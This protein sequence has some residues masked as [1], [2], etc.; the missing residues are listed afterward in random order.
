MLAASATT[1]LATAAYAQP[2]STDL[3]TLTVPSSTPITAAVSAAGVVWYK[4]TLTESISVCALKYMDIYS[5][6]GT[7]SSNDSEIGL[8]S[9]T[10]ALIFSDDDDGPG[11]YSALSFGAGSD[12]LVG[13]TGVLSNGRDRNL[14]PGEYYLAVSAFS[15]THNTTGWSVTSTSTATGNVD[16][17]LNLGTYSPP[18][19]PTATD[20]G[21]LA[22]NDT[23]TDT[24]AIGAGATQWYKVTV[25]DISHA[26]S[27]FVDIDT[28]GT[29]LSTNSTRLT[30]Y[31]LAGRL[32][33]TDTID[34]SGS[35]SQLS[36][37][38]T[39]PTRPA[40]GTSV[41]YNGRDGALA[42]CTYY[43]AVAPATGSVHG[44]NAFAATSTSTVT[45]NLKVN[46]NAGAPVTNPT[47]VPSSVPVVLGVS[48]GLVRVAV[49]PGGNPAST[50]I[51]VTADLTAV[52]GSSTQTLFDNGTNGD[53]TSG[54]N[55]YSF[56]VS[57]AT[58]AGVFALPYTVADLELRSSGGN[59]SLP[60]QGVTD[61]G[62]LT[63]PQTLTSAD[64]TIPA[65]TITWFKFTIPSVS[66]GDADW[67]DIVTNATLAG[68]TFTADTHMGLFNSA[69]ALATGS[70]ATS[71]DDDDGPAA[72]SALTYGL[73]SP[74]RANGDGPVHNGRD[75]SLAAGTYYLAVGG[76]S[77]AF[78]AG[79][80]ATSTSNHTSGTVGVTL[81]LGNSA[82]PTI[83]GNSS[84]TLAGG[85]A[86]VTGTVLAGTS[87]ASTSYTVTGNFSS[88]G[89]S[90]TQTMYDDMTN[91]DLIPGDLVYSYAFAVSGAQPAGSYGVPLSVVDNLARAG[92]GNATVAVD[93][94]GDA[95]ANARL[96]DGVGPVTSVSGSLGA[97][98][99][100]MMRL[101][102]C[103]PASFSA[104]TVG[105]TTMDTQLFLFNADGSGIV[106][107][108]DNVVPG[109]GLQSA[110]TSSFTSSLPAGDYYLAIT[111]YDKDPVDAGALE[112]W[113]DQ[114]GSPLTYRIEHA[115]DGLGANALAGWNLAGG[116]GGPY[117]ISLSGVSGEP[118]G[119]VCGSADFDGDGDVGTD[120]DIEAFFACLGGDCCAT[121]G[122][123]DFDGDGDVGTDLDIEAF[124][125]VLGGG[126]C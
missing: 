22:L 74:T 34:G 29:V 92:S 35:L 121:C 61:L 99:A 75:G 125:R 118:C 116:S 57:T 36:Y 110:L 89:G 6:A 103:D 3:G 41:V 100:D 52:G 101:H 58:T 64:I 106:T 51:T 30:L 9:S 28:E 46:I 124:F 83:T 65:A 120:L 48:N 60:V 23:R 86:L 67:L 26:L 98:D 50:G 19:A 69:G 31:N 45:G 42:A 78:A 62:T 90:V 115:P 119:P 16:V 44:A 102:I 1:L 7:L 81:Y 40:V 25:S 79:F 72:R 66:V 117:T 93:D 88:L 97:S 108:D 96:I 38:Q 85:T 4:F 20:W 111:Q 105:G 15:T 107:N 76:Y 39:T 122:S 126:E 80:S 24:V 12:I 13:G 53:V 33:T 49:T 10:G 123:A 71:V 14:A 82:S 91:G 55:T 59:I 104:S 73:A 18:A 47:G 109:T 63:L 84:S 113:A 43:L 94:A 87:P 5:Q 68:G 56:A 8:Y 112:I 37:G 27:R 77:S 21:T 11:S 70:S 54:D 2:A 17:F 32:V 114:A 95:I